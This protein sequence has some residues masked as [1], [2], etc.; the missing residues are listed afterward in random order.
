MM[1]IE[2]GI[3][4]LLIVGLL[5]GCLTARATDAS[6][7]Y[8][9]IYS[10][11][12]KG[13]EMLASGLAGEAAEFYSDAHRKLVDFRSAYPTWNQQVVKFRLKYLGEKLSELPTI[14]LPAPGP[15]S[16]ALGSGISGGDNLLDANR[17]LEG[18][19]AALNEQ[20]RQLTADN[21]LL[22]SKLRQALS[23]RPAGVDPS[24]VRRAEA[25][26]LELEK[27]N[28]L[29]E[30]QLRR[31]LAAEVPQAVETAATEDL[32]EA[33]KSIKKYTDENKQ[34][35]DRVDR[36]GD[37]LRASRGT[38]ASLR[39][40]L[41]SVTSER[42]ALKQRSTVVPDVTESPDFKRLK[43][44]N[45]RLIDQ[46]SEVNAQVV[47]LRRRGS[48]REELVSLRQERDSLRQQIASLTENDDQR[49]T[50]EEL[51]REIAVLRREKEAGQSAAGGESGAES[52]EQF[53]ALE[54]DNRELRRRLERAEN[55]R[56][57]GSWLGRLGRRG[58]SNT[59]ELEARLAVLEAEKEPY[60][61]EELALLKGGEVRTVQLDTS[62]K[63]AGATASVELSQ[64]AAAL[65]A[66]AQEA[67]RSGAYDVAEAKYDEILDL[68]PDHAPSLA[69]LALTQL[70]QGKTGEAE[71][72]LEMALKVAPENTYALFLSGLVRMSQKRF[73][74]AVTSLSRAAVLDPDDAEVQNHLG[75]ALS[76]VGHRSAAEA[77]LRKAVRLRPGYGEAH[78]NLAVVYASQ[79][80]PFKEL[81]K[82]HYQ[83]AINAGHPSDPRIEKMLEGN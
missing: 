65:E 72:N 68:I 31:T 79:D 43:E 40:E 37:D 71:A 33:R 7:E 16:N 39:G 77:A 41:A 81:A 18:Q 34:L 75:I 5:L 50:V 30:L 51:M 61:A 74:D 82:Y 25:K 28:E 80:P 63:T 64:A 27:E 59:S 55:S 20:V 38:V 23:A 9:S 26:I 60:S 8:V 2:I 62:T 49:D 36:L 46:L 17:L 13:D 21:S 15:G 42:D 56:E 44:E 47:G 66:E 45:R 70:K 35:R 32:T 57:R 48:S 54:K 52:S 1:R 19:V 53:A 24:R 10:L 73:D 22:V 58:E 3:Q 4:R 76:E 6:D 14:D 67:A 11:I 69:S 29:I 12:T 83:K 78:L